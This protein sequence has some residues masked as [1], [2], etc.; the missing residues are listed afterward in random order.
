MFSTKN[1][2]RAQFRKIM[3]DEE[4]DLFAIDI[5]SSSE[6]SKEE[7][8]SKPQV[9][10]DFQSEEDFQNQKIVWRAK[11]ETGEVSLPCFFTLF[12][13][14]IFVSH[15]SPKPLPNPYMKEHTNNKP[16]LHKTLAL[17]LS[18]PS[19]P[20]S[21]TILHAIEELYFFKRYPE[22]LKIADEALK[23]ELM[24]EFRKVVVHYRGK[25]EAKIKS[26]C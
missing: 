6:S 18:N 8:P 21:Q 4:N 23:G 25:C 7:K 10:R 15:L 1:Q 20:E 2:V 14:L 26:Q 16:Q 11:F 13:V 22:A 3:S 12:S 19:K 5:D 17:P 9:P 24:V